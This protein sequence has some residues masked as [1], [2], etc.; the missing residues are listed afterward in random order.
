MAGGNQTYSGATTLNALPYFGLSIGSA[1]VLD[2]PADQC[3]E[4]V[5]SHKG[6]TYRKVILRDGYVAGMVFGGDTTKCG[7]IYNLMRNRI[8]VREWKNALVSDSFGLL[9]LPPELW[10][11]RVTE[12][13][14]C[15]DF[16]L[17]TA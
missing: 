16:E 8:P 3:L 9:S 1:G 15:V 11:D 10:Q 7:L 14:E 2:G 5:V 17:E 12:P 13:S 4:T 6:A